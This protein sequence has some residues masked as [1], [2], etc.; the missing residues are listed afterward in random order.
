MLLANHA[1]QKRTFSSDLMHHENFQIKF[2]KENDE[3][4][5][6]LFPKK[7]N[8]FHD[9]QKVYMINERKKTY[10]EKNQ[11]RKVINERKKW[12]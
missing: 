2:W 3:C 1:K 5:L 6:E 10:F 9:I 8:I 4:Y 7:K 11:Y 12:K